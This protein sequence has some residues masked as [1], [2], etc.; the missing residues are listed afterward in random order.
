MLQCGNKIVNSLLGKFPLLSCSHFGTIPV[1]CIL[2]FT[3]GGEHISALAIIRK[4]KG[5]SQDGLAKLS[6]VCRV[7]IARYETGK[8]T[9]NIRTLEKL[10]EALKV[11]VGKLL[12]KAG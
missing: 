12:E 7:T 2:S 9:P 1:V 5:L 10:S 4:S 8:S 6:G 3:K 11:P